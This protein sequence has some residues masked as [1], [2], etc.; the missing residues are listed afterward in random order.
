MQKASF[1]VY[2]KEAFVDFRVIPFI[3]FVYWPD[4]KFGG[5]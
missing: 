1:S 5:D 3:G 4:S 2:E